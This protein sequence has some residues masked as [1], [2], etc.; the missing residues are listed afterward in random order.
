[1]EELKGFAMEALEEVAQFMPSAHQPGMASPRFSIAH[2]LPQNPMLGCYPGAFPGPADLPAY[3]Q[4]NFRNGVTHGEWYATGTLEGPYPSISRYVGP[5]GFSM[6]GADC[7]GYLGDVAKSSPFLVANPSKRKRRVL[8]SRAQVHEL[9]KRFEL[10]KYLTAFERERLASITCLTPNQVKIWF[11][12]HRY[13]MKKQAKQ[14]SK[15]ATGQDIHQLCDSSAPVPQEAYGFAGSQV[16]EKSLPVATCHLPGLMQSG[17]VSQS[18]SLSPTSS[19]DSQPG[20]KAAGSSLVF[21]KPW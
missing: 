15:V 6:P 12:N 1:M 18:F 9:E 21:G 16:E 7:L 17:L 10:Q 4:E 2:C 11:Q 19:L 5:L 20:I 13:K 3:P 8:F 14:D